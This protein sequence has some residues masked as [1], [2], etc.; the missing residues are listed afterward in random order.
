MTRRILIAL[1]LVAGVTFAGIASACGGSDSTPDD[2]PK[3]TS[4]GP[5]DGPAFGRHVA[6]VAPEHPREGGAEFGACVSTMARG[7]AWPHEH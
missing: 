4:P 6:S 5:G 3:A 7:E 1:A 2:Q